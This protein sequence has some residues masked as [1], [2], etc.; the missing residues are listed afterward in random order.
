MATGFGP[1]PNRIVDYIPG[2]YTPG[3][4][5]TLAILVDLINASWTYGVNKSAEFEARLD[6]ITDPITGWLNNQSAPKISGGSVATP[7]IVE[8]AVNIPASADAG[9]IFSMFDTKYLELVELLVQKF[10]EFRATYFPDEQS[11]YTAAENWLREAIE[12]PD[13]AL[14]PGVAEQ[15]LVEDRDRI[16]KEANRSYDS[17]LASFAAR[18]FPLPPGAAASAIVQLRQK[19]EEEISASSRKIVVTA[20]ERMQ[21]SIQTAISLRQI[22]MDSAVK[23]IGALASGPDM[24]SRLVNIGYDAQSK[25]ISAAASFYNARINAAETVAKIGQFNVSTDL[26]VAK[27]NQASEL[28]LIE[29]RLRALLAECQALAQMATSLFNNLHAGSSS[30]YNTSI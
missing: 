18:R 24:A 2:T 12:N 22:A 26:E 19:A 28:A 27:A 1:N 21:W 23:Y 6:K 30:S 13:M 7:N 17:V 29:A 16:L 5:S 14:P 11:V 25:L 10:I 3:A 15:L 9:D 4:E 8:P 20:I